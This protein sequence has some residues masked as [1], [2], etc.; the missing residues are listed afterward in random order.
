MEATGVAGK[1]ARRSNASGSSI[2]KLWGVSTNN[3]C[4][5]RGLPAKEWTHPSKKVRT[6]TVRPN[7]GIPT[8]RVARET[9]KARDNRH[10]H[11]QRRG[12]A[13]SPARTSGGAI[14]L[15]ALFPPMATGI[16]I[17]ISTVVP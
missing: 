14:T 12:R 4:A 7:R 2:E 8:S 6:K 16:R 13:R 10:S 15:Q 3:V 9:V 5:I 1:R 11:R 17:R